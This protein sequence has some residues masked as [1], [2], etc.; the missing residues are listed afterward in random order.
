MRF[1]P[2]SKLEVVIIWREFCVGVKVPTLE[3]WPR[4][5]LQNTHNTQ[6]TTA[7]D[8]STVKCFYFYLWKIEYFEHEFILFMHLFIGKC[9]DDGMGIE[10]N[11]TQDCYFVTKMNYC[12]EKLFYRL[13]KT[14]IRGWRPRIC[15]TF[16]I[17]ST[18]YSNSERSEQFLVKQ[19]AFLTCS[20]GFSS[21][22]YRRSLVLLE[23]HLC[24][25]GS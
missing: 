3:K 7:V 13:R 12:E 11:Y 22:Y 18:I 6:T 5:E 2:L 10:E 24:F 21:N 25:K 8:H 1:F 14:W 4:A 16:E 20:W 19:N 9:K 23:G 15:E 17:T